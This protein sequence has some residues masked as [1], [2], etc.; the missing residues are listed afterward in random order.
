MSASLRLKFI[1]A[2]SVLT[3]LF[4]L[5]VFGCRWAQSNVSALS[6]RTAPSHSAEMDTQAVLG[7]PLLVDSVSGDWA[8]VM[9]ADSVVCY[10]PLKSVVMKDS[11]DM[12]RWRQARRVIV[13]GL[14]P[15]LIVADT[16]G[17]GVGNIVSDVTLCSV[18]EGRVA[19]GSAYASVGLPDGRHGFLPAG[20]VEDFASWSRRDHAPEEILSAA[21]SM[22]GMPY[23]WGGTT[24]KAVDCSGFTQTCFFYAGSLIPRNSRGQ[25]AAGKP[26]GNDSGLRPCDLLF[27][28]EGD[29]ERIT[30]VGIY[31][32]GTRFIH[33]SGLVFE[34]SF[35]P[36]DSLFIPRKVLSAVRF[37]LD[38]PRFLV[39]LNPFYFRQDTAE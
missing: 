11:A 30:H 23:L 14:E 16:L 3:L 13:T 33:S 25:A 12:A 29:D 20:V 27:F 34:S 17:W 32:G 6:L 24:S 38:D 26:V 8:R 19:P 4:P 5:C 39:S 1:L 28:G 35:D 31:V 7:A 15:L 22:T 2:A 21:R 36:S 18:L 9:T 10:A 37:S